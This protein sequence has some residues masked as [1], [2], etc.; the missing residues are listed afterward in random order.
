MAD[1]APRHQQTVVANR[2]K[3]STSLRAKIYGNMLSD[4]VT[5]SYLQGGIFTIKL[6]I[7]WDLTITENENI[8][9]FDPIFV[10]PLMTTCEAQLTFL[11]SFTLAPIQQNGPILQPA[12]I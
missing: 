12:P 4:S 8:L 5:L 9:V 6:Q 10:C 7:L 3:P 1:V 11:A 2:C